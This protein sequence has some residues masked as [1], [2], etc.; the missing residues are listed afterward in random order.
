M[1]LRTFSLLPLLLL[2]VGCSGP[3]VPKHPFLFGLAFSLGV[4]V[5]LMA[6][7]SLFFRST[8]RAYITQIGSLFIIGVVTFVFG[9][10]KPDVL[11]VTSASLLN[12]VFMLLFWGFVPTIPSAL[13]FSAVARAFLPEKLVPWFPTI[14]MFWYWLVFLFA[15]L[16][17][18]AIY[19]LPQTIAIVGSLFSLAFFIVAVLK[20]RADKNK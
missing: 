13:L 15:E 5:C 1:R 20:I 3:G 17:I 6:C 11:N 12:V 8:D 4:F 19:A 2:L 16:T 10:V 18:S 9:L 7:F 14:F